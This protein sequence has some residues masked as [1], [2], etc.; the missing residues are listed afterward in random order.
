[1]VSS[2]GD[3]ASGRRLGY[4][5][6]E[7]QAW[8]VTMGADAE[9]VYTCGQTGLRRWTINPLDPVAAPSY[10]YIIKG[11]RAKRMSLNSDAAHRRG[12][13]RWHG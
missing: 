10:E 9:T 6:D 12:R 13:G 4:L 8:S 7:G 11:D 3:F 5:L 2:F 1:M